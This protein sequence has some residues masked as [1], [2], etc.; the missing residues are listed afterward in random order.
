MFGSP[1]EN[2]SDSAPSTL[3]SSAAK[4]TAK[5]TG[6]WTKEEHQRFIEGLKKFGKNWKQV[7]DYVGTRSGAQIR[8]HAQKFFN[9]LE[10]EYNFRIDG[11]KSQISQQITESL[12]KMSEASG[13]TN[14]SIL[15]E[16]EVEFGDFC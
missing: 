3:E 4:P 12:R 13:S 8:S 6:R 7:E 16:G 1:Q 2:L 9:R 10:R 5:A 14:L 15:T 11:S